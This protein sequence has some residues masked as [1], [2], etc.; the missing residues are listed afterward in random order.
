[1]NKLDKQ[2]NQLLIAAVLLIIIG[3]ANYFNYY[4]PLKPLEKIFSFSSLS[5]EEQDKLLKNAKEHPAKE[6]FIKEKVEQTVQKNKINSSDLRNNY[7]NYAV[8]SNGKLVKWNK[9]KI[10]V[11][12]SESKYKNSIH[13]ALSDYNYAFEGYFK[14]YLAQNREN[15]D[16]KIDVVD[17]FSSND[18][19]DSIYMAGITNNSFSGNDK[20]LTNS[21][22]QIL[23]RKPNSNKNVSNEDVYK[24]V[25]HELG[26]AIGIIGHSPNSTDVMYASSNVSKFSDRDI[27][28]I[29][30]MYSGDNNIIK[31][32]T[33][34]FA[35]TKLNEA[36]EY[37]RKSPNKAISWVNLGRVYYD[38]NKKEQALD[39]YKR[40]L[41][42]EP[43]NPLIYQSMAECYY[44]SLKYNTAIK[45]YNI[46]LENISINEQKAPLLNMIG[47]CYAKQENFKLAYNYFKEAYTIDNNN[48]MLLKNYLVACAELDKKEE[49]LNTI[50]SYKTKFPDV[51]K[52]EFIQ[53]IIKWAK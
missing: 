4:A 36:E 33:K 30:L 42:I 31:E 24:V 5:Q 51:M 34:D 43:K 25:L 8:D 21:I 2:R 12:V 15:S 38:L 6:D 1:M 45:Y 14:F 47:M 44:S 9:D 7:L 37:A 50:N 27:A 13:K 26:H 3:V 22:I 40:A 32:E 19:K 52:E 28:T 29:K 35:Q 48:R 39:A 23:S 10:T 20:H 11:Y 53:D 16:I 18:N 49:A 46:A 17:H 41:A